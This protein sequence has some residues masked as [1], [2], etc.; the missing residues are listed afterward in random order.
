MELSV[1]ERVHLGTNFITKTTVVTM[2]TIGFKCSEIAFFSTEWVL[3]I[4]SNS[5]NKRV[6]FIWTALSEVYSR[7]AMFDVMQKLYS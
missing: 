5:L 6:L 7:D 1:L 4:F 3:L 2:C